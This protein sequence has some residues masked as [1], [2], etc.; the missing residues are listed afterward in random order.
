MSKN[1]S[2][3][4]LKKTTLTKK[5]QKKFYSFRLKNNFLKVYSAKRSVVC[6]CRMKESK[7]LKNFARPPRDT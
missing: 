7:I 5:F 1:F 6:T 3:K 2:K 4:L